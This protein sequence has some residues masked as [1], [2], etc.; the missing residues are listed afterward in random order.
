[1]FFYF[2][3]HKR[4]LSSLG[5]LI[6][7][8]PTE[9][10][11]PTEPNEVS[12]HL[13]NCVTASEK[14]PKVSTFAAFLFNQGMIKHHFL[15]TASAW[16]WKALQQKHKGRQSRALQSAARPWGWRVRMGGEQPYSLEPIWVGGK[17]TEEGHKNKRK[18]NGYPS[19]RITG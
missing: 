10:Y 5:D 9:D 12:H 2:R 13:I 8:F 19:K 1:M 11:A 7:K 18:Y 16:E 15:S 6:N 4:H 17:C 3:Y 14:N